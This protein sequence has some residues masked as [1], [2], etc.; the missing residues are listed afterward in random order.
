MSDITI[1]TQRG[2]V[3]IQTALHMHVTTFPLKKCVTIESVDKR[4]FMA[5]YYLPKYYKTLYVVIKNASVD[6]SDPLTTKTILQFRRWL[7]WTQFE[8]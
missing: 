4:L 7:G 6:E 5:H 3:R 2:A 1:N 8:L